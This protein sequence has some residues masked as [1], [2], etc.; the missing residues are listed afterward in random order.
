MWTKF[1]A[2][3]HGGASRW[4][5]PHPGY[6]YSPDAGSRSGNGS[7]PSEP[8]RRAAV[9][10]CRPVPFPAESDGK[11][12]PATLLPR[13]SGSW[14]GMAFRG[15]RRCRICWVDPT[16]QIAMGW[17]IPSSCGLPAG[18]ARR[19]LDGCWCHAGRPAVDRGGALSTPSGCTTGF[20]VAGT[21]LSGPL[22]LIERG[23]LRRL[24]MCALARRARRCG[25]APGGSRLPAPGAAAGNEG[26]SGPAGQ[27]VRRVC[28]DRSGPRGHDQL[29]RHGMPS[30]SAAGVGCGGRRDPD[31]HP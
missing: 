22:E 29:D 20:T 8:R 6:V 30:G 21:A 28:G 16:A 2:P 24:V 13:C 19:G 1:A 25:P 12:R 7:G 15:R 31:R 18:V 3:S 23:R 10:E 14:F 5:T 9:R 17:G 4:S 27:R 11:A 26:G